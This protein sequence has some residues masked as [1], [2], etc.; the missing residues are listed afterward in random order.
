[1][2]ILAG[3]DE[4]L[5]DEIMY[6]AHR[7]AHPEKYPVRKGVLKS[8]RRQK[9]NAERFTT[10]TKVLLFFDLM[11]VLFIYTHSRFICKYSMVRIFSS[12]VPCWNFEPTVSQTCPMFRRS[13]HSPKVCVQLSA[14]VYVSLK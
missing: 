2:Y 13:L 14:L 12:F 6:I 7:A 1:M 8:A 4:V 9:E 3:D 10:P 11:S 5:R